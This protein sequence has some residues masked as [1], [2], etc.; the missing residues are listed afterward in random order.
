MKKIKNFIAAAAFVVFFI[1][2]A[3]CD[4][5]NTPAAIEVSSVTLTRQHS[6]STS[7]KTA[8]YKDRN[9]ISV[10]LKNKIFSPLNTENLPKEAVFEISVLDENVKIKKWRFDLINS[11]KQNVY[12]EEGSV[13]PETIRW[14]ALKDGKVIEGRYRYIL[15]VEIWKKDRVT[16]ED[17]PITVDVT[18]PLL[19][20]NSSADTAVISDGKFESSVTFSLSADD[21]SGIN[22]N[23]TKLS[24]LNAKNNIE[25]KS[26]SIQNSGQQNIIWDG[27]DAVY[28]RTVPA[29]DYKAVFTAYDNTGNVSKFSKNLSAIECN[30]KGN[31]SDIIVK[32]PPK[33]LDAALS[34]TVFFKS[35][36]A[37]LTPLSLKTLNMIADILKEYPANKAVIEGH[38]DSFECR[39]TKNDLI[40]SNERAKSVYDFFI[41]YGINP[42]RLQTA[43]YG[44]DKPAV[45]D[46][47]EKLRILNRR[48]DITV[49]KNE[50]NTDKKN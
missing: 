36:N 2:A 21:E 12:T 49:I 13:V 6:Y 9:F 42:D 30:V 44:K 14:N 27:K 28:D 47:D 17:G 23:K 11:Q 25:I 50:Q 7:T 18:P 20:L 38:T 4:Q 39:K 31:I 48:V 10:T 35:Q 45:S 3:Y 15:T 34:C 43:G 26:W 22:F 37:Q 16:I 29:G 5:Q 19:L 8:V 33:G 46:K 41:K 24:V 40:I 32:E 1:T